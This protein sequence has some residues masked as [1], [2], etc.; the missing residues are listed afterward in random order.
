MLVRTNYFAEEFSKCLANS[1]ISTDGQ[2][3]MV[4]FLKQGF[5]SP[6]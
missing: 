3:K 6:M 4:D 1:G 5:M 2:K